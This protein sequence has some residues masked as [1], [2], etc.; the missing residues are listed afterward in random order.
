MRHVHTTA[1]QGVSFR[2]TCNSGHR[3]Y[4]SKPFRLQTPEKRDANVSCKTG[5]KNL[6]WQNRA[7]LTTRDSQKGHLNLRC[8]PSLS[9]ARESGG[10]NAGTRGHGNSARAREHVASSRGVP[11]ASSR[12]PRAGWCGHYGIAWKRYHAAGLCQCTASFKSK[13]CCEL[14]FL[15]NKYFMR[16]HFPHRDA[17]FSPRLERILNGVRVEE[18]CERGPRGVD[19][20]VRKVYPVDF[21]ASCSSMISYGGMPS[22]QGEVSGDTRRG[23]QS[24]SCRCQ[25]TARSTID[26]RTAVTHSAPS[27]SC[28]IPL[29]SID[30]RPR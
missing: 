27:F 25:V 3:V 23:C 6:T 10:A 8:Y 1:L 5:K 9:V 12:F 19:H 21:T 30:P 29:L 24:V 14:F 28:A 11:D 17:A 13:A 22:L 7:F 18:F 4:E 20:L 2:R 16:K 15:G 26:K